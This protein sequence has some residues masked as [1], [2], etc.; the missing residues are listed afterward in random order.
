MARRSNTV[1]E[2]LKVSLQNAQQRREEALTE[3]SSLNDD[4]QK[5][6]AKFDNKIDKANKSISSIDQ[7]ISD[8]QQVVEVLQAQLP[9]IE[10]NEPTPSDP[11]IM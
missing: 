6:I 7:E 10:D 8:L 3:L 5:Q 2:Q 1:L 9:P 11:P 4:K